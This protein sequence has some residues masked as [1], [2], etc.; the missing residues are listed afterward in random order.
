[1]NSG[2]MRIEFEIVSD[3]FP[4]LRYHL[5]PKPSASLCCGPPR[6]YADMHQKNG[7][8]YNFLGRFNR[9]QQTGRAMPK[10]N[11]AEKSSEQKNQVLTLSVDIGGT[12][13]KA[14]TLA[15]D[16]KPLN[17]RLRIP[18]PKRATPRNVIAVI[19]KL[20]GK[21]AK[22]SRVSAGFPGVI[23]DGVVYTAA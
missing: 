11:P 16:G 3:P 20:A 18:T 1:P 2:V 15:P 5:L 6:S 22:F 9:A 17:E 21:S 12:G 8:R 4:H 7:L 19:R 10:K 23:K 14:W 13:I